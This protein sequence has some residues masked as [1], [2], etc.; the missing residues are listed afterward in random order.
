MRP[1]VERGAP[2]DRVAPLDLVPDK[3][4][5]S[6]LALGALR[7][8]TDASSSLT[9]PRARAPRGAASLRARLARSGA[10]P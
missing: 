2:G 5:A 6:L 8:I 7:S 9:D 3:A 10:A 4:I 1:L